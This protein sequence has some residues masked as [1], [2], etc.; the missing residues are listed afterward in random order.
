[1]KYYYNSSNKLWLKFNKWLL[2]T[3]YD[4]V[5]KQKIFYTAKINIDSLIIFTIWIKS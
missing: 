3:E 4:L 5:L 2:K 1:M